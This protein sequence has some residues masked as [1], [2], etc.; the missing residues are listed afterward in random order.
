MIF[1]L[2]GLFSHI[3]ASM[4]S[5]IKK[6]FIITTSISSLMALVAAPALVYALSPANGATDTLGG[7]CPL[8]N[9]SFLGFPTWY[10]YLHGLYALAPGMSPTDTYPSLICAPTI[11]GL[12]DIWLI[13]AAIVEILLRVAGL[14]AVAMVIYGG[15]QYIISQGEPEQAKKAQ[16]TII[17]ALIGL[18]IAVVA[19]T[20]V[21]FIAGRFN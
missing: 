1:G 16:G 12:S 2:T 8:T 11:A 9:T 15:V 13:A 17:N 18:V 14:V 5:K 7:T 4:L 10:A 19:A 21:T 20:I 6:I 3:K